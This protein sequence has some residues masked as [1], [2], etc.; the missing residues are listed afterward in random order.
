MSKCLREIRAGRLGYAILYTQ[1]SIADA[2]RARAEKSRATTEARQ[3]INLRMS[4]QQLELLLFSNFGR[5]DFLLTLTYDQD[6]L[7]ADRGI[8]VKRL[9]RFIPSLRA[10]RRK[11][12]YT[13]KY[14]YVTENKHGEGRLHHHMVVNGTGCDLDEL[15][16]LWPDGHV[17][18]QNLRPREFGCLAR[19]LTKEAR[20]YG[21]AAGKKTWVASQ[22]LKR[23]NRPKAEIVPDLMTLSVPPNADPL[24]SSGGEIRI[25]EY[26]TYSYIKYIIRDGEDYRPPREASGEQEED[27]TMWPPERSRAKSISSQI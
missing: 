5:D 8:A 14:V 22:N 12:G 18:I 16:S 23:P 21:K 6:H 26:G 9:R 3:K 19:Y 7:P 10:A 24:E 11:R 20:D 1:P 13:L 15:R 25:G 17:Y 27:L 4:W 2:P